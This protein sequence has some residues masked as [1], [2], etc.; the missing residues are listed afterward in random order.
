MPGHATYCGTKQIQHSYQVVQKVGDDLL[1]DPD[2]HEAHVVA[3]ARSVR[4]YLG[5]DQVQVRWK[6]VSS[7]VG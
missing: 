3:I 2:A 4:G 7:S 1:N 6:P 5:I